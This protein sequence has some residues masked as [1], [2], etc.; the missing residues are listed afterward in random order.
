M[1]VLIQQAIGEA[2][3]DREAGFIGYNPRQSQSAEELVQQHLDTQGAGVPPMGRQYPEMPPAEAG[4]GADD[5]QSEMQIGQ[6]IKADVSALGRMPVIAGDTEAMLKLRR[7]WDA[8]DTL[9][10]MHE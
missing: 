5:E 10:K 2:R 6:S 4:E 3:F 1:N 8:A 9:T 7:I